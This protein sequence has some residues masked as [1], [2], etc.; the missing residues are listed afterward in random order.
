MALESGG[1]GVDTHGAQ[2]AIELLGL[3][4]TWGFHDLVHRSDVVANC[5]G[6]GVSK[7][8]HS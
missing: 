5:A 2:R 3:V 7:G 8:L 4:L 1:L 6:V